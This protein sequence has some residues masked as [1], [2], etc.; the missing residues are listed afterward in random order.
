MTLLR[1]EYT[2]GRRAGLGTVEIFGETSLPLIRRSKFVMEW[3]EHLV[4]V[5]WFSEHE[6]VQATVI[7]S[8]K[9]CSHVGAGSKCLL[10]PSQMR[11]LGL[12]MVF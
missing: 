5:W 4:F 6:V 9:S 8:E 11:P 12:V 1:I 7:E 3:T 10:A 2:L